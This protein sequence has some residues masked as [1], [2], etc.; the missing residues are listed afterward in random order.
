MAP[1]ATTTTSAEY[2]SVAPS[3]S[4]TTR[5]TV[6]PVGPVS[7]RVTSV[8]VSRLTLGYR[9]A[10][11][12]AITAASALPLVGQAYPS[13]VAHRMHA[14]CHGADSSMRMPLG[15]GN[16]CSPAPVRS[17]DSWAIRGSWLIAG[18][19]YG[20]SSGGSVGSR[21]RVPCTW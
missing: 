18:N 9:R 16:G 6:R 7:S 13:Q 21:P 10:G 4:T 19:G 11:W 20:E 2:V 8:L 15:S 14:D 3:R 17:A 1:P 12:T 5:S